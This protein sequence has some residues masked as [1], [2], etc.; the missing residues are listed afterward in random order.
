MTFAHKNSIENYF[1]ENIIKMYFRKVVRTYFYLSSP[2]LLLF[3][4]TLFITMNEE[5]YETLH[6]RQKAS[7]S[8]CGTRSCTRTNMIFVV[9]FTFPFWGHTPT[10]IVHLEWWEWSQ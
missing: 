4:F 1:N 10:L 3:E 7:M 6:W 8:A 2:Y 5:L 9:S